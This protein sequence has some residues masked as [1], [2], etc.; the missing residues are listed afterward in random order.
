ME[1]K[2]RGKRI[3]SD[4]WVYGWYVEDVGRAC[5]KTPPTPDNKISWTH[6]VVPASVGMWTGL[7]DKKGVEIY[8]GDVLTFT[9][10]EQS[11]S[12]LPIS[13]YL[14]RGVIYFNDGCFRID[15]DDNGQNQR[16]CVGWLIES[17]KH[18]DDFKNNV[19]VIGN[20]TDN[21]ELLKE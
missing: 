12:D 5:I 8:E 1:Y 4:K 9:N 15:G 13:T 3:N 16:Q 19:E 11:D 2:F 21:P 14:D 10:I 7:K 20:T 18:S 17:A 6:C